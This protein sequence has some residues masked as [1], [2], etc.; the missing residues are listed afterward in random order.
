[1]FK[2]SIVANL[3]SSLGYTA[4]SLGNHEFD[5]GVSDL[6][7]FTN[8]IKDSYPMLACNLDLSQVPRLEPLIKPYIL[9]KISGQTIAIVGYVTPETKELAD[10]GKVKFIDE[11]TSLKQ[12]VT[13]LKNEHGIKIIIAVGHSGYTKD[14]E[15]AQEVCV[16]YKCVIIILRDLFCLDMYL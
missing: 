15:I 4:S 13:K 11:I 5:D 14:L 16:M 1:M 3:T 2:W 6:E 12:T 10:S 7:D 8:A 9:K